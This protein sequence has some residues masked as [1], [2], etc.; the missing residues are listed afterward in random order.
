MTPAGTVMPPSVS[1]IFDPLRDDFVGLHEVWALYRAV[2]G[3]DEGRIDLLN[4]VS[5]VFF[6]YTQWSMYLDVILA[7]CRNTDPPGVVTKKGEDRRNLTLERLVNAVKADDSTFGGHLEANEWAAVKKS[8]DTDFEEIRSKRIAHNDLMKMIARHGGHPLGWPS[9]EQVGN[10]LDLCTNLMDKVHQHY[11]GCP[12]AFNANAYDGE[13]GGEKLVRVLEEFS[14]LHVAEVEAGRAAWIIQPPE[15]W[16]EKWINPPSRGEQPG[17]C[18][19]LPA[20]SEVADGTSLLPSKQW[21]RG[22]ANSSLSER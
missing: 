14:R 17:G 7:L 22:S 12:F 19:C 13:K 10:F 8:R 21:H 15:G 9:R 20:S 4:R 6:G 2:F 18:H 1:E 5:V 11:V 16:L 3:K